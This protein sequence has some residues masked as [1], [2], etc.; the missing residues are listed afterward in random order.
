MLAEGFKHLPVVDDGKLVGIITDRDIKA[1]SHGLRATKVANVMRTQL[2]TL[3]PDA[4]IEEAA[5]LMLAKKIG[6]LPVVQDGR[7]V[8]ILTRTDLLKA[9][10][11]LRCA[12]PRHA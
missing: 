6:C 2:A 12:S 3:G 8:G 5:R 10:L 11:D 7:L 4:T 9:L 1:H